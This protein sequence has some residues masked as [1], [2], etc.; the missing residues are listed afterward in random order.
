MATYLGA[1]SAKLS[2][3]TLIRRPDTPKLF[4]GS[5]RRQ[6]ANSGDDFLLHPVEIW[7]YN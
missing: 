6:H 7:A 5:Q 1:K 2:H 3:H 4:G